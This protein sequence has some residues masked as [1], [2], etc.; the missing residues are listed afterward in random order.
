VGVWAGPGKEAL[1]SVADRTGNVARQRYEQHVTRA[2]E[3]IA[4]VSRAQFAL[5]DM[6]LETAP[7]RS[8]GGSTPNGTDDLFTVTE[9]LQ[10]FADD[11]GVER[12]T[13]EDGAV[14][15]PPPELYGA[16]GRERGIVVVLRTPRQDPPTPKGDEGCQQTRTEP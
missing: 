15:R 16:R 12:R 6:T 3:L 14:H 9:S 2:K 5:S 11:I 8:V 10:L 7:M 13:V 1:T 4:Q